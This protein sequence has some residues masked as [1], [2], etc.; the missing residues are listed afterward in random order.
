MY[1]EIAAIIA[2]LAFSAGGVARFARSHAWT[3]QRRL[4]ALLASTLV[5]SVVAEILLVRV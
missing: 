3:S 1:A 5:A 2:A 4:V